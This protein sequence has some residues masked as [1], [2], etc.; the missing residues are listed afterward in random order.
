VCTDSAGFARGELAIL[1]EALRITVSAWM[2]DQ[3]TEKEKNNSNN[4]RRIKPLI[5]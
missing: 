2:G 1:Y 4:T 3:I 5:N